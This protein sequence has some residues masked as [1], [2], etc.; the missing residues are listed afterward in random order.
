MGK[1]ARSMRMRSNEYTT[2]HIVKWGRLSY[3][4][5]A[6]RF[7]VYEG[8]NEKGIKITECSLPK[9]KWK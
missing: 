4:E 7:S 1:D 6:K 5:L 3:F 9:K 2:S 8:G